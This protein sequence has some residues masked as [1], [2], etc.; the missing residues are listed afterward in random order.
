MATPERMFTFSGSSAP[1]T[2]RVCCHN[3]DWTAE[4]DDAGTYAL[5]DQHDFARCVSRIAT[6]GSGFG[7][8]DRM[9]GTEGGR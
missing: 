2:F 7:R 5:A 1:P 3:C 9:A 8:R 4:G 6:A